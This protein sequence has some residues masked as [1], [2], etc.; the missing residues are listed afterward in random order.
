[1]QALQLI[2]TAEQSDSSLVTIT[3]DNNALDEIAIYLRAS[4]VVL[5]NA[6]IIK[7]SQ[8][9]SYIANKVERYVLYF[10]IVPELGHNYTVYR[11]VVEYDETTQ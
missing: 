7:I 5:D 4:Y 11:A 6:A 9:T 8:D 1:M 2:A 10:F 3:T